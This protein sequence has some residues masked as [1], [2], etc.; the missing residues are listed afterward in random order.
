MMKNRSRVIIQSQI[1]ASTVGK[2]GVVHGLARIMPDPDKSRFIR[3]IRSID[4]VRPVRRVLGAGLCGKFEH[5]P[6]SRMNDFVDASPVIS[7]KPVFPK[8]QKLCDVA[9]DARLQLG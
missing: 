4:S 3:P 8:C 6:T 7:C 2:P 9:L 5:H 1:F